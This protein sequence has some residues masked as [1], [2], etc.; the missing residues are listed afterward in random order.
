[1]TINL[2][3]SWDLIHDAASGDA[4]ARQEFAERYE[5]V[6]RG[7]LEQRWRAAG[8]AHELEDAVQEVFVDCLRADGALQRAAAD[9][10][11]FRGFLFGIVRT[12]ALRFERCHAQRLVRGAPAGSVVGQ[13]PG[14]DTAASQAF[15]REWARATLRLAMQIH[16]Q[17]ANSLGGQHARRNELLRLRFEDGL[18]IRDIAERWQCDPPWL[19]HEF[20]RARRDFKRALGQALGLDQDVAPETL[21]REVRRLWDV[22]R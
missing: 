8:R 18:P 17:Q 1:V 6:V 3:T 16:A 2:T 10:G 13:L 5:P 14:D 7:Y 12:V 21:E 20:A 9:R 22:L 11:E 4:L 19:H 15:D